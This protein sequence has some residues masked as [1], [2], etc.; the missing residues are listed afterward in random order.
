MLFQSGVY[1]C[2]AYNDLGT[3][4]SS[5]SLRVLHP[6]S[7]RLRKEFKKDDGD[8]NA[9]RNKDGEDDDEKLVLRCH[10]TE[11]D[12]RNVTFFWYH[13][14][15]LLRTGGGPSSSSDG[16]A[17]L[18]LSGK[19]EGDYACEPQ[20]SV[21]AGQRYKHDIHNFFTIFGKQTRKVKYSNSNSIRQCV[22]VSSGAR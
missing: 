8:K 19:E 21:G 14:E 4:R 18:S 1:T 16:G 15:R 20:N 22:S 12:P 7:C 6:P 9:D 3:L 10:V 2:T 5:V 17:V 11:G 13:D